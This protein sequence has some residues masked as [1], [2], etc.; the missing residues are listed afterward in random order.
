MA[1]ADARFNVST[2]TFYPPG[3]RDEAVPSLGRLATTQLWVDPETQ[4]QEECFADLG[5]PDLPTFDHKQELIEAMNG[6]QAVVVVAPTG[7]GKSTQLP[8]YALEA[9]FAKIVETQPRRR[10]A[11][12]V[13]ERIETELAAIVGDQKAAELVSFRTGGGG[14]GKWD[15]RIEIVTDGLLARREGFH[16]SQ[17]D[18]ELWIIDEVHENNEAMWNLLAIAKEKM[19]QNPN[20]TVVVTTATPD[21]YKLISYLTDEYGEAPAVVELDA[22]MY[23]VEYREEPASTTVQEAIKAAI[24]I[25]QNPGAHGGSN[26]IQIFESGKKELKDTLDAIRAGLPTEI[27]QQTTLLA[28]HAKMTPEAL[29]PIYKD[30]PEGIKIICQTKIGETSMTIPRTRY[31]ITSGLERREDID[32]EDV[33][34]LYERPIS[35]DSMLQ[36]RG[37]VGRTSTGIFIHTR[38]Q[39]QPFISFKDRISHLAPEILRSSINGN[40]LFQAF[41]GKSILDIEGIDDIPEDRMLRAIRRNQ[42]LGAL[43]ETGRIT[44]LGRK[45][46]KYPLSPQLARSMVEAEKYDGRIRLYMAALTATAEVGGLRLFA[47]NATDDWRQLTSDNSSDLLAQLD[48]FIALQT[49]PLKKMREYDIDINNHLRSKEHFHKVAKSAGITGVAELPPPTEAEREI[50]RDCIAAGHVNYIY[51]PQ[52]EGIYKNLDDTTNPAPREISN[53]SVVA[54]STRQPVVGTPRNIERRRHGEGEIK[55]IIENVTAVSADAIARVAENL[56]QWLP[57]GFALRNGTFVQTER[58]MLGSIAIGRREVPAEPS[59]Q[60]RKTVMEHVKV[61]PGKSLKE[62]YKIKSELERLAHRASRPIPR[63]TEEM[64][65][66]RIDRATPEGVTDPGHVEENLRQLIEAEHVSLDSFLTPTERE[67]ILANS[68]DIIT[69]GEHQLKLR[70]RL[71]KVVAAKFPLALIAELDEHLGMALPD[72]REIKFAYDGDNLTLGQLRNRLLTDGLI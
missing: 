26:T 34:G 43:D 39:G 20:F 25:Y 42:V 72:G 33:I 53:R 28:G 52:G 66:S 5:N 55:P 11:Q 64:I 21:R 46:Y 13:A 9:G 18:N 7:T 67:Q 6:H 59:P 38:R 27:L 35:V 51:I 2:E 23:D 58:Q 70:Y 60:L 54:G 48:M 15:A 3:P 69:V 31:V 4:L 10:A 37:R 44:P 16:P 40:V 32:E 68:P 1:L 30:Q 62:L 29:A 50:L 63:L 41:R 71:G 8:Q 57:I 49:V 61:Q 14:T 24:D 19:A 17:G 36:Q 45:M 56:T 12:N 65:D 47:P 22:K